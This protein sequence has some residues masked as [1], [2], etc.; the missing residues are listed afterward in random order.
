M[1]RQDVIN[2]LKDIWAVID[3]DGDIVAEDSLDALATKLMEEG[4]EDISEEE[5]EA[6]NG[7]IYSMIDPTT[8]CNELVNMLMSGGI[9]VEDIEDPLT[10]DIWDDVVD[11]DEYYDDLTDE[12]VT[13][14]TADGPNYAEF[15]DHHYQEGCDGKECKEDINIVGQKLSSDFRQSFAAICKEIESEFDDFITDYEVD[16][17]QIIAK[18]NR[19]VDRTDADKIANAMSHTVICVKNNWDAIVA[20]LNNQSITFYFKGKDVKQVGIDE[21]YYGKDSIIDGDIPGK[22][23]TFY[24]LIS[25][26][27][28]NMGYDEESHPVLV[29]E[30]EWGDWNPFGDDGL[31]MFGPDE[32]FFDK[33]VRYIESE[34]D[35]EGSAWYNRDYEVCEV[36]G[37]RADASRFEKGQAGPWALC[38]EARDY[39]RQVDDIADMPLPDDVRAEYARRRKIRRGTKPAA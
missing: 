28:H 18:A 31:V 12:E 9:K 2:E 10:A 6:I 34:V 23:N 35:N 39:D 32:Q 29:S 19:K 15:S 25:M 20:N 5:L 1:T 21:G 26:R 36:E 16:N 7:M 24:Q 13:A 8:I 38:I 14:L 22:T 27:F 37:K 17:G 30:D 11:E 33:I 4:S 3:E